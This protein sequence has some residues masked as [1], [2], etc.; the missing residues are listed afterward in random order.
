MAFEQ[1]ETL[2]LWL[3]LLILYGFIVMAILDVLKKSKVPKYGQI[4]VWL[5]LFL[6][7]LVFVI[8]S[9]IPLFLE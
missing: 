3:G 4:F 1:I 6:S 2:G 7:P 8:K 5:V 9:V